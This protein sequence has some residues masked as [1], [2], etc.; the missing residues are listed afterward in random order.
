MRNL[1]RRPQCSEAMIQCMLDEL[2]TFTGPEL[3]QEDDITF[4]TLERPA[5]I[6]PAKGARM[7]TLAEFTIP[8]QPGNERQATERVARVVQDELNLSAERIERLKT[9]V[10]EAVMN[11][12]EH[13]NQYQSDLPVEILVQASAACLSVCIRDQGGEPEI[14]LTETPD[15]E[16]KL[17]GL[18]S[19]RGWGL[20]LIKNMV[21]E[22][23]V[24]SDGGRHTV[25]LIL[26][27]TGEA[28][29]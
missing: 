19:P 10:A 13:G 29:E 20:F 18:Q 14:P 24:S 28:H 2:T 21:D 7:K 12:M 23:K 25:E 16:A 17:A 6:D 26:N 27:L 15:L 8:S 5:E 4:V 11:A 9:A 22:M 1:M 3:E